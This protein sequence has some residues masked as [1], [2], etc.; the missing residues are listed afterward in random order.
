MLPRVLG[1]LSFDDVQGVV[2]R[3]LASATDMPLAV[4]HFPQ[5]I[6]VAA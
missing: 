4:R 5:N 2:S 1:L 3:A 6:C